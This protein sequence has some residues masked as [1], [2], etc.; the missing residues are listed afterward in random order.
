MRI[1]L[2]RSSD[3]VKGMKTVH[4]ADSRCFRTVCLATVETACTDRVVSFGFRWDDNDQVESVGCLSLCFVR[5][6]CRSART[7]VRKVELVSVHRTSVHAPLGA[8]L[9]CGVIS[10]GNPNDCHDDSDV[11]PL[12]RHTEVAGDRM[13]PS[14]LA[15]RPL[16]VWRNSPMVCRRAGINCHPIFLRILLKSH[17]AVGFIFLH[18]H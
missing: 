17:L 2:E 12:G 16:H 11:C 3:C 6:F 10:A 18:W 1:K 8:L 5:Q 15:Y 7:G 14:G 13:V 9:F 4:S